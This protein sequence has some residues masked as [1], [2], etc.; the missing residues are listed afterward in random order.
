MLFLLSILKITYNLKVHKSTPIIAHTCDN[1]KLSP[2]PQFVENPIICVGSVFC[3]VFTKAM[4]N[5]KVDN[6]M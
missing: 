3:F 2:A 6:E 5:F 4:D 1:T